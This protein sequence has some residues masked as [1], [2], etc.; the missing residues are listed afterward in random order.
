MVMNETSWA[1]LCRECA[2]C[3]GI[4]STAPAIHV[5]ELCYHEACV[6][7][8]IWAKV[9]SGELTATRPEDLGLTAAP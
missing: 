5:G 9:E 1:D 3:G 2:V 8:E 6:P 4:L 7:D